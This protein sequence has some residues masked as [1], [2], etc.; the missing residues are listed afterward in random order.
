MR[1]SAAHNHYAG[2]I[3][4][5]DLLW[6][7]RCMHETALII[8]FAST[9]LSGVSFQ[10]VLFISKR[11]KQIAKICNLIYLYT[12]LYQRKYLNKLLNMHE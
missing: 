6:L 3:D 5:A 4:T 12:E 2:M 1:R 9:E 10:I 7:H 11:M 8:Q